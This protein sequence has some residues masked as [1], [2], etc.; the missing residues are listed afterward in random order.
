MTH[1]NVNG[2]CRDILVE[3]QKGPLANYLPYSTLTEPTLQRLAG[4]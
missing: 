1:S 2:R 3:Y 4:M